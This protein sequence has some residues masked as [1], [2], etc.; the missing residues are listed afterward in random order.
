[1]LGDVRVSKTVWGRNPGGWGWGAASHRK[2]G[3]RR[4]VSGGQLVLAFHQRFNLREI[5]NGGKGGEEVGQSLV[6]QLGKMRVSAA[7]ACERCHRLERSLPG[8]PCKNMCED[9][10]D[11]EMTSSDESGQLLYTPG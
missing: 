10:E 3:W 5:R 7:Q 1:M 9:L 11:L 8:R 2:D 4:M 6:P